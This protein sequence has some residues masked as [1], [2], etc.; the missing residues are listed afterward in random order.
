MQ[1]ERLRE[2]QMELEETTRK[3][4]RRSA[5]YE[6]LNLQLQSKTAEFKKTDHDIKLQVWGLRSVKLGVSI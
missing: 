3:Y 2:A 1:V 6:R 4:E 5:E